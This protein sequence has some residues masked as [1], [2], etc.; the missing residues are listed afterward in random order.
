MT[1][2]PSGITVTATEDRSQQVN[3]R[4]AWARLEASFR[5]RALQSSA[6]AASRARADAFAS[7]RAWTWTQWRDQVSGPGGKASMRKV[8]AGRVDP[9]W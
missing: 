7:D 8:L 4:V 3:R 2:L 9:P 1:H 5:D 6:N